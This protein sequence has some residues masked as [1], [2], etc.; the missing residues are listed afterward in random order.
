MN[1]ADDETAKVADPDLLMEVLEAR[2][3][4]EGARSEED[5]VELKRVN[6][7]RIGRSEEV[8]ERAFRED[9]LR[10]AG[11][12]AVSLRYWVNIRESLHAW[13]EGKPITLA[14]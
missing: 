3:E 11:D 2:E 14:H 13:E 4:I 6:E 1:V 9:D 8:L 7:E 5:L 10:K 12:E